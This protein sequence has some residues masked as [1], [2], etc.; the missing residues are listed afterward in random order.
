MVDIESTCWEPSPP[1]GQV[2]EII[3][4]GVASLDI[5]D[6]TS[7]KDKTITIKPVDSQVSEFCT[8][9]TGITQDL[10]D[11]EGIPFKKGCKILE[12]EHDS[13]ELVW[14]SWGDYDREMFQSQCERTETSYPFKKKHIN[15]SCLFAIA[16]KLNRETS[17]PKALEIL[18]LNFDGSL[19]RGIDDAYNAARLLGHMLLNFSHDYTMKES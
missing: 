3:E 18:G 11:L 10:V 2:S 19:H 7:R 9:L 5:N 1:E 17:I 15:I 8:Q 14:A 13:K 6:L 16:Q 4:I 12:Q